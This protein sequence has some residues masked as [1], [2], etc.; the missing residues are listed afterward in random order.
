MKTE[1]YKETIDQLKSVYVQIRDVKK[2]D[3]WSSVRVDL[4]DVFERFPYKEL[5]DKWRISNANLLI[6]HKLCVKYC[7]VGII[8]ENIDDITEDIDTPHYNDVPHKL[9]HLRYITQAQEDKLHRHLTQYRQFDIYNEI[10]S[11]NLLNID[12]EHMDAAEIQKHMA[13]I[14]LQMLAAAAATATFPDANC[15][16]EYTSELT[17]NQELQETNTVQESRQGTQGPDSECDNLKQEYEPCE[18][19]L[20]SYQGKPEPVKPEAANLGSEYNTEARG[21]EISCA[22]DEKL[23]KGAVFESDV[24][25]PFSKRNDHWYDIHSLEPPKRKIK[26]CKNILDFD[27]IHNILEDYESRSNYD[28]NE[29]ILDHHYD[30]TNFFNGF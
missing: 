25:E 21:I 6:P 14:N 11:L 17:S 4:T 18:A 5:F 8:L 20:P 30:D 15:S 12:I 2:K 13:E 1:A 23:V 16:V 24:H 10:N 22:Q 26:L 27:Q 29:N 9:A 3:L 28:L 7:N 19:V